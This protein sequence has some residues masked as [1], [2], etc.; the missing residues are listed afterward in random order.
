MLVAVQQV[1]ITDALRAGRPPVS[2]I[3]RRK[4]SDENPGAVV[5]M[6][7]GSTYEGGEWQVV[8]KRLSS[9]PIAFTR[10]GRK[11]PDGLFG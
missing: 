7:A 1:D 9:E 5:P 4:S 10:V 8:A 6:L 2:I 3:R 11:S